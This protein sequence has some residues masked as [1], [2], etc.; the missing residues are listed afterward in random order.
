MDFR[1]IK[2]FLLDSATYIITVVVVILLVIYVVSL[3]QIVGSSMSPTLK[4]GDI[5]LLNKIS[6]RFFKIKRFDVVVV[7]YS[8]E[9]YLVKRII[10]LPGEYIE[11]K[12]NVLYVNEEA[13]DEK[14][15][16]NINT[17]N[18]S[19]E[20][21]GYDKIPDDMYLVLGDNREDSLDSRDIGLVKK[22]EIIGKTFIR[23]WP[24]TNFKLIK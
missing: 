10:G 15:L 22:K 12:D 21:L 2:E 6:Y 13:V 16:N 11:Y 17:N 3:Q 20:E 7:N 19:L 4:N 18:F 1:D 9:K 23:I 8:D 24:I 14:Y 5:V